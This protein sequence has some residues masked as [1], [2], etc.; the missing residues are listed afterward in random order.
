M[1]PAASE[2]QSRTGNAIPTAPCALPAG[3]AGGG[4]R[5]QGLLR[6]L[7]LNPHGARQILE[8]RPPQGAPHQRVALAHRRQQAALG[9]IELSQVSN[10]VPRTRL[11]PSPRLLSAVTG[12]IFA[13]FRDKEEL[14][15]E[16]FGHAPYTAEQGRTLAS[17]L[18]G[19][20]IDPVL[21]LAAAA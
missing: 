11:H 20:G 14:Y 10:P 21:I 1:S 2:I 9:R 16:V 7:H 17:A 19:V 6:A 8:A 4:G 12:A 15:R 5:A 18:R 3:M 13:S